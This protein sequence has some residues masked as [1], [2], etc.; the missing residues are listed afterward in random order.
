MATPDILVAAEPAALRRI[1]DRRAPRSLTP[2]AFTYE[3][4]S[5][6]RVAWRSAIVRRALVVADLVAAALALLVVVTTGGE[7][8]Q[9]A[10]LA[11]APL[12]VVPAKLGGLYDRD[13][14]VVRK[15]TI[16]ELQQLCRLAALAAMLMWLVTGSLD[17]SDVV[18]LFASLLALV[19]VARSAAR[20]IVVRRL[21]PERCL[22]VGDWDMVPRVAQALGRSNAELVGYLP[23]VER[24]NRATGEPGPCAALTQMAE[25]RGVDRVIIAP[26]VHADSDATLDVITR[27]K[28]MGAHVSILPRMF[29]VVGSSVQFDHV[30]GLVMLGVRRFG[31]TRSSA[32]IKRSVDVAG[33]LVALA[34]AA[35]IMVL[36]AVAIRLE[37]P[38][39]I[40]FRQK[41]VGRNGTLITI[42]KFRTM[43]DGADQLRDELRSL[44][45]AGDGLFKVRDDPRVTRVGRLLRRT[46]LDELPQFINVLRGEMSLVGPRPLVID[47]DARIA[48]YHRR[49][50]HLTP[51]LTGPWQVLGS[52]DTRVPL[53]DMVT[54]DYLYA[55]NW[56][57]WSDLKVLLR[58][59]AHVVRARGV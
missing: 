14:V 9:L 33:A 40:L 52:G 39:P 41:R 21:A 32:F 53:R 2:P 16:D 6:N 43:F 54:I 38:G 1:H 47:E 11:A 4:Q 7:H 59:V 37:S 36:A 17:R 58:T 23:L 50:L 31:L 19:F 13:E 51:G 25:G 3:T 35:P 30:D 12:V 44:S 49:R 5:I 18:V 34:V 29:E 26:G 55:A 56:T 45:N 48:G 27:A 57:L 24:R 42:L 15:S 20:A 46:S 22:L 10:A 8:L 28:A